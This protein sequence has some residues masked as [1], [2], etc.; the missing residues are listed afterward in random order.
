MYFRAPGIPAAHGQ[1]PKSHRRVYRIHAPTCRSMEL[2]ESE[3]LE[4]MEVC[5]GGGWLGWSLQANEAT[6]GAVR[7]ERCDG[8]DGASIYLSHSGALADLCGGCSTSID[9][10]SGTWS[11]HESKN[12]G[13]A[14]RRRGAR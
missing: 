11:I 1:R 3:R 13:S 4:T 8:W 9:R 10:V 7:W 6:P 12:A 5:A 2:C 14:P